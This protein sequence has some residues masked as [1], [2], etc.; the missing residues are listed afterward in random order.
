MLDINV[1]KPIDQLNLIA[2]PCAKITHGAF[3]IEE[4]ISNEDPNPKMTSPKQRK[5]KVFSLGL[6]FKGLLEDQETLCSEKALIFRKRNRSS[7]ATNNG[8]K[9][10]TSA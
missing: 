10:S 1:A 4:W 3:P 8:K 5:K 7:E 9:I 6:K 2:N